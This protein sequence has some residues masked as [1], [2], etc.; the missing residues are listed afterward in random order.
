MSRF[1]RC[2]A[3]GLTPCRWFKG[4]IQDHCFGVDIPRVSK[5]AD[6][7][8]VRRVLWGVG[9]WLLLALAWW[10]VLRRDAR[11][12]LPELLVPA[13]AVVV[14]TVV[15]LYWVRHNLGIYQRKGPRKG[16]PAGDAPWVQ[17]SLGR[18]LEFASGVSN[19]R[20]VRVDLDGDV[21]RYE[22]GL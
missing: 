22:V 6:P 13:V 17:D 18:R 14:V 15:T 5:H 9:A 11:T 4:T 2:V 8:G 7:L 12:W 1:N 3:P 21:K 10:V 16:L 20:V 19:A